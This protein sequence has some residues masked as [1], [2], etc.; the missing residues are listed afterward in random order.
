[1][2]SASRRKPT[3]L[4]E[5]KRLPWRRAVIL[6]VNMASAALTLVT[7]L[8]ENPVLVFVTGRYDYV[9]ARL[10]E[11]RIN[12]NIVRDDLIDVDKLTNLTVVGESFRFFSAPTRSPE[13]LGE[14]R[15]TCMRI[16]SMNVTINNLNFD[17]FWGRG[18]RRAQIFLYS[19]SAPHCDVV[20]FKPEWVADCISSRGNSER[21][22]HRY[23]LDNFDALMA[24]RVIQA[25][26]EADFGTPGLPFL[27][28]LGRPERAFTY[29]TD[30]MVHQCFWAGGSYHVEIQSSK[31]H[32]VPRLLNDDLR[33]GLFQTEPYDQKAKVVSA[34]DNR[35]W[36]ASIITGAYGVVAIAL[37]A[38]GVVNTVFRTKAVFY[39]PSK[40][41]FTGPIRRYARSRLRTRAP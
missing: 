19:M 1:M 41:R 6:A 38:R 2:A 25:G 8:R 12:Y 4:S 27:R 32:A 33:Y 39:V 15:S 37:I 35:G 40:L 29:M 28:C 30:L 10:T 21:E 26:V 17:D 3:S 7:G 36:F 11:G 14:D 5:L 34:I 24:S 13:N 20:N 9:R 18:P 31:C 23:I 22:C 16:N